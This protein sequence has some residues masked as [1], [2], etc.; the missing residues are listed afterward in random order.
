MPLAL[1]AAAFLGF[2][3]QPPRLKTVLPNGA[4][5]LVERMAHEKTI[6]VQLWAP[7]QGMDLSHMHLLEHLIAKGPDKKLDERLESQGG[8]LRARTMRSAM[9]F[10]IS[11]PLGKLSLAIGAVNEVLKPFKTTDDEIE[12]EMKVMAQEFAQVDD[13]SRLSAAAWQSA[14]GAFGTDPLGSLEQ[15][16]VATPGQ[17]EN[18]QRELFEPSGIV[19]TIAGPVDLDRA[20]SAVRPTLSKQPRGKRPAAPNAPKGL[21]GR[22]VVPG[23]YGEARSA[24]VLGYSSQETVAALAAALAVANDLDGCFVTYT[25]SD[26]R[27][28]VT[29]GRTEAPSGVGLYIDALDENGTALL[30][31]Q[32][33]ALA[34]AWIERYLTT[35]Q[36]TA[37]IRGLLLVQGAAHRPET[38]LASIERLTWKEFQGGMLALTRG[39][40]ITVVGS[41]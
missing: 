22:A 9:Q 4:T 26:E 7:V 32:G 39:R 23:A 12:R 37:Y 29:V 33:K 1:C 31:R 27:G 3:G 11:V 40:A 28:L 20:T 19:V 13:D 24:I 14:Y 17:L 25:P 16:Q 35:A 5:I 6:S 21:P 38:M 2:Q 10:E 18:L 36:G 41:P 30:F 15:M 34:R 8:F